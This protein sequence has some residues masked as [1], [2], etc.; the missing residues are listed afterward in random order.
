MNIIN[1]SEIA[2]HL[3]LLGWLYIVAHVFFLLLAAFGFFLFPTIAVISRNA[4]VTM[5]LSILGTAFGFLMLLLALPGLAVGYGLLRHKRWARLW[6]MI[7]AVFN[8][9][10]FPFGTVIGVYAL[11]VLS[12]QAAIEFFE[13]R[14]P[15]LTSANAP[16]SAHAR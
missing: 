10:N 4:D 3:N 2:T 7:I 11:F 16:V 1:R 15:E 8:L 9:L 6:G 14:L 13:P 12:Q 5:V